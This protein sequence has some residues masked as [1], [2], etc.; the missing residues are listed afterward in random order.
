MSQ[1]KHFPVIRSTLSVKA[2]A[3]LLETTYQF[4]NVQCQLIK[5]TVR[6]VY[7]VTSNNGPFIFC[8]Y[9]VGRTPA[10][11][12]AEL[13]LLNYLKAKGVSVAPPIPQKD[14]ERLLVI[15]APEG[16]RY[17]MLFVYIEGEP[18]GRIPDV[19]AVYHY[20][21]TIAQIHT[22]TDDKADD[23]ARPAID[24]D[25]IITQSIKAFE[26]VAVH[27]VDDTAYLYQVAD[28]IKPKINALSTQKPYYGL[29][30]GDVI[31]SNALVNSEGN[32]AVLDFDLSGLSWRIYDIASYLKEVRFWQ[33]PEEA[34]HAFLEGY[35]K[36]RPVT[37]DERETIPMFEV[38]RC[39]F[40]LG[41]PAIRV[42]EWG[43][44]YLADRMID[45]LLQLIKQTMTQ[46]N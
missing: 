44:S 24:F 20:G 33:A 6:D 17:A 36:V 18:L 38:A 7:R 21:Y 43:S 30:H 14:G 25:L 45:M 1:K 42:N 32:I 16:T 27:R 28:I 9:P 46:V 13:D 41:F 39:I 5:K 26:T 11:I 35:E 22:L 8:I 3:Q 29:V 19:E 12:M 2:L 37:E 10:E 34:S 40:S 23:L 4:S 31:P 15:D